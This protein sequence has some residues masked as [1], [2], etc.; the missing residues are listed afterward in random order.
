ME[1]NKVERQNNNYNSFNNYNWKR[2][3]YA[4]IYKMY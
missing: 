4:E 1:E 2:D 3:I